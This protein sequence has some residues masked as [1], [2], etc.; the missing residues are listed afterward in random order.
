MGVYS[1]QGK[2]RTPAWMSHK[3]IGCVTIVVAA[4]KFR[5]TPSILKKYNR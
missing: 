5:D 2:G 4:N 1:R 3:V